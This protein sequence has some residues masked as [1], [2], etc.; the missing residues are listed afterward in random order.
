MTEGK[1]SN[2]L[3]SQRLLKKSFHYFSLSGVEGSN[4]LI[5]RHAS[6]SLSMKKSLRFDFFNSLLGEG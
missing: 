6:T 3:S 4:L 5:Y 2:S 1:G